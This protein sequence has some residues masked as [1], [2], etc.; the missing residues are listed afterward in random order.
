MRENDAAAGHDPP[1]FQ[2]HRKGAG[3]DGGGD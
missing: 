2:R 1:D 3:D